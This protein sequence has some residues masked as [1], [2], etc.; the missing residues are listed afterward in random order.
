[1]KT[2]LH[3]IHGRNELQNFFLFHK[4]DIVNNFNLYENIQD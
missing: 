1:M 4:I 2:K 3:Q